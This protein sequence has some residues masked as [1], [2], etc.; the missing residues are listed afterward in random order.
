MPQR[1]RGFML[2]ILL[3]LIY[4]AF[5]SLGLPDSL[6]GSAWPTMH[7]QLQVPLGNLG[8]VTMV[9][10]GCTIISSLMSERLTRLLGTKIVTVCSVFLTAIALLG[11]ST[12]SAFW[13][14]P[15]WAIPYGLG[16]GAV[17]A[18][19]NNYVA[20]HFNS[21][22]MS[23]LHCF[24][25]LGA[26][27]S[28]AIM[29]FA[30]TT[31]TWNNGYRIVGFVQLVIGI[32]LL[33]TLPVW[34]VHEEPTSET[35]KTAPLGLSGA[36]KVRGVIFVLLGFLGYCALE[37]TAMIWSSSYLVTVRGISE[38]TA[39][40]LGSLFYI[41]MT[42]GRF[43]AGFFS[44]RLGDRNMIRLGSAIAAAG[45][46]LLLLPVQSDLPSMVGFLIVGLGCAPIYPCIIHA[47]P[48]NF[49]ADKSQ[50]I[51]GIQMAFAYMGSTFMPPLFGLLAQHISMTLLP[52]YLMLFLVLMTVMLERMNRICK[53]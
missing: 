25:G 51:I 8:M 53:K 49:G 31:S 38:D 40:A 23:W 41:G 45:L 11:F 4:L 13:M 28:P 24:W 18:A 32:I 7:Q 26:M 2:T 44:D 16:A 5:I 30:L 37:S 46:V 19:L 10:S 17:D 43:I 1:Q 14:L 50:A 34:K 22:Q 27:I 39:A 33:L 15:L 29:S 9:I 35:E 42:A 3:A 6:L 12:A 48:A 20:L 36:L 47:T 52:W 21:R